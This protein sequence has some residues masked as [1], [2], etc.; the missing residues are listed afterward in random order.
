MTMQAADHCL[1]GRC[2]RAGE[3]PS[4]LT[5]NHAVPTTLDRPPPTVPVNGD[6]LCSNQCSLA[7]GLWAWPPAERRMEIGSERNSGNHPNVIS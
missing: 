3:D 1:F 4:G 6:D 2:W 5:I 7:R